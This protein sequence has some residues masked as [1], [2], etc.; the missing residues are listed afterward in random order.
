MG[1]LLWGHNRK[2]FWLS[3]FHYCVQYRVISDRDISRVSSNRNFG[4]QLLQTWYGTE[5]RYFP[6]NFLQNTHSTRNIART[7]GR[8]FCEV[9]VW[10]I[11]WRRHQMETFSALLALCAGNSPVTGEFSAQRPVTRSFEVFF[12]LRLNKQLS[13]QSWGWWLETP[14]HSL[15]CHCNDLDLPLSCCVALCSMGTRPYEE[16]HVT[17][18][19]LTKTYQIKTVSY[20]SWTIVVMAI[21]SNE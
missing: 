7:Y 5:S 21:P 14:S 20:S 6:D 2:K 15:W 17:S 11:S 1:C 19:Y 9:T 3:S 18:W 10:P 13:K 8:N 4:I 12:D 16:I